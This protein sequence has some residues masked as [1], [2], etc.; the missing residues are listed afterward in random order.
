MPR[1]TV[2]P[3]AAVCFSSLITV[4]VG[5]LNYGNH[6]ANDAVLKMAHEIRLR[7]L[8]S[9]GLSETDIGGCGLI[10]SAA[11]VQYHNQAFHGDELRADVGIAETAAAGFRFDTALIRTRD[12]LTVAAAQCHMAA[13]DYAAGRVRRLPPEFRQRLA[14]LSCTDSTEAV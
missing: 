13:F 11:V 12:G 8:A 14:A 5:D 7:W 3:P 6:L 10:M 2:P 9:L 1:P 4:Q